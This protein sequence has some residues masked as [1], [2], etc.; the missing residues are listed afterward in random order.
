M[1]DLEYENAKEEE[2]GLAWYQK[3]KYHSPKRHRAPACW[4]SLST[5]ALPHSKTTSPTCSARSQAQISPSSQIPLPRVSL[6]QIAVLFRVTC[7][8]QRT[9]SPSHSSYLAPLPLLYHSPLPLSLP[10]FSPTPSTP[11]PKKPPFPQHL[12]PL[13]Y[14]HPPINITNRHLLPLPYLPQRHQH[15]LP[16]HKLHRAVRLARMIHQRSERVEQVPNRL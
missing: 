3:R 14:P 1:R 11:T 9:S 16:P 10:L 6:D 5:T 15:D 7:M 12:L 13:L 8:N 2:V 4:P